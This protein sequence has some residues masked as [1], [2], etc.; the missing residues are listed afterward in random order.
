MKKIPRKIIKIGSSHG[1]IIPKVLLDLL[2][3]QEGS[4]LEIQLNEQGILLK[5]PSLP[6][7]TGTKHSKGV[8]WDESKDVLF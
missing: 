3:L 7:K 6:T 8:T 5:A 1:I 4:E 2:G